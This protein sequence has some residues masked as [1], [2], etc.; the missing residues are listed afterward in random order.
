MNATSD[1]SVIK[2]A[3]SQLKCA[4]LVKLDKPPSSNDAHLAID[5]RPGRGSGLYLALHEQAPKNR[6][7]GPWRLPYLGL[8]HS[9]G[10]YDPP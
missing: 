8:V 5:V 10:P 6:Q 9:G 2:Q 4:M 7:S 1:R 3:C